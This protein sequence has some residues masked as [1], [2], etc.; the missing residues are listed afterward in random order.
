MHHTMHVLDA[1]GLWFL[2][3]NIRPYFTSVMLM[4]LILVFAGKS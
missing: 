4:L 2:L 3:C 1:P